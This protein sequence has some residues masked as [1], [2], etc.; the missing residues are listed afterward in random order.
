MC[1]DKIL[2]YLS[3]LFQ[4][5]ECIQATSSEWRGSL[6]MISL[7]ICGFDIFNFTRSTNIPVIARTLSDICDL[8]RYCDSELY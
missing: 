3:H 4:G 6:D 7:T 1:F 5:M 2:E 8:V